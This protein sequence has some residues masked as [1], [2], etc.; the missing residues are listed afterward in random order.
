M[1]TKSKAGRA[2]DEENRRSLRR[3]RGVIVSYAYTVV[4]VAVNLAYVPLLLSVIGRDEYGLYQ[5][6][7]SIMAYIVSINSV[8]SAGVARYYG[9]YKAAGDE[10]MMESTLAMARRIYLIL[11]V[12]A[13]AVA[14]LLVPVLRSV[15]A[16]SF[17]AAQL[18]EL[19]A[20][21]MVLAVNTAV[22]F[23]NTVSIAAINANERF[24][25]L[26]GTQLLTLVVQPVL[27]LAL[28]SIFHNALVITI[29]VLSMNALCAA[30]QRLYADNILHVRA[31]FHGWDKGLLKGLFAF[32][33]GIVMVTVADQVFWNSGKLIVGYFNGAGTVA[34]YGIGAQIYSTYMSAGMA[35]SG[36]F[37]QRVSDLVCSG[38]LGEVSALFARVGRVA[39]AVL[40]LILGGF[41]VLGRDFVSLWAGQG[42]G[43]AFWVAVAVMIPLTVD[44][45]QNLGLTILQVMNRYA[46]RG[47]VYLALAAVN[48]LVS[49]FVV[50]RWGTV[51]SAVSSGVCMFLGNGIVMNWY[52][53][54]RAGLDMKLF[55]RE[56]AS[57]GAPLVVVAAAFVAVRALMPVGCLD[58]VQLVL[59]GLAYLLVYLAVYLGISANFQERG[60]I[61]GMIN[62]SR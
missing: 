26:K 19:A 54:A 25:F 2:A 15:Y 49:V 18:D 28:G 48:I 46:F 35:I 39:F 59:L 34:V 60:I 55:W 8:L 58:W 53:Q 51:G 31:T 36:V 45:I 43:D 41:L 5:L 17:S 47:K 33:V 52:Y 61:F 44:L 24:V 29:V 12:V 10:R 37:F 3:Q 9:I 4:Q 30:L 14:A 23:N 11:S 50:P 22:T 42:Y 32:S 56:V 13:I 38:D 21:V 40:F 62:R 6:V 27:V 20:M 7:G 57:C 16:G 1:K